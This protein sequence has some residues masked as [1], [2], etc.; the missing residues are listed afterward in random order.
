M[1]YIEEQRTKVAKTPGEPKEASRA[2]NNR[3]QDLLQS[4]NN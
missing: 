4:A 3:Y 2:C 1:T